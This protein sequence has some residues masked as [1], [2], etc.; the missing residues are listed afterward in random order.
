MRR[1]ASEIFAAAAS[2][3]WDISAIADGDFVEELEP[4]T[5][6]EIY[7]PLLICVT[8]PPSGGKTGLCYA[9]AACQAKAPVT[10]LSL[11]LPFGRAM[12]RLTRLSGLN[13]HPNALAVRQASATWLAN[14]AKKGGTL[15]VDSMGMSTLTAD[16]LRRL[17]D[18]GFEMI[19]A[20]A[21][22]TKAGRMRGSMKLEHENDIL[23]RCEDRTWVCLRSR[24]E[25]E[26][27][28]GRV[29]HR[30]IPKGASDNV[31]RLASA[32][33]EAE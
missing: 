23:I 3:P 18:A 13:R 21:Q 30:V 15:V 8:G 22:I 27:K 4:V 5:G 20:I 31:V 14:R 2:T 25:P 28:T 33:E 9:I 26:G 16:D 1:P 19:L 24:F 6:L 11:E 17:L 29:G 10:V 7:R 32:T 12:Q